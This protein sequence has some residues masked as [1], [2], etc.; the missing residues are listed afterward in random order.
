MGAIGCHI[1][2][3]QRWGPVSGMLD[4]SV[5]IRTM[6]IRGDIAIFNVGGGIVIDSQPKSEYKESLLKAE[7]LLNAIYGG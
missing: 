3:G 5:A 7:A 1:P 4:L 2:A 6:V